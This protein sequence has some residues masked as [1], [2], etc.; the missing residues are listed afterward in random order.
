[1][2]GHHKSFQCLRNMV[3]SQNMTAYNSSDQDTQIQ[4]LAPGKKKLS[5]NEWSF[6]QFPKTALFPGQSLMLY[7]PFS[8][9]YSI[10]FLGIRLTFY[11]GCYNSFSEQD[12][13]MHSSEMNRRREHTTYY[14]GIE[15]YFDHTMYIFG[16]RNYVLSI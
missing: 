7:V 10:Q 9:T 16:K 13:G 14:R 11:G 6:S 12:A 3:D 8:M 5:G 4:G 2:D 15:E 1:M